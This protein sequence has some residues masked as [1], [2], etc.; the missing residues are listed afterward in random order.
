MSKISEKQ[1]SIRIHEHSYTQP[2]P[3]GPQSAYKR[4]HS[5]KIL[6]LRIHNETVFNMDNSKL[7]ELTLLG[8]SA[9]CSRSWL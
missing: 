5:T 1:I 4:F 8:V 9:A 2:I 6:L 7:T 3:N